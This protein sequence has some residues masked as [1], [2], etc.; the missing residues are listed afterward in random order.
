MKIL[1]KLD[2][3]LKISAMDLSLYMQDDFLAYEIETWGQQLGPNN[4]ICSRWS[5]EISL[6]E[7]VNQ[8]MLSTRRRIN[9]LHPHLCIRFLY[10]SVKES[11]P[12]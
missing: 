12:I 5:L 3:W 1:G 8:D 9:I 6:S 10:S 7:S 2:E 11:F 4:F